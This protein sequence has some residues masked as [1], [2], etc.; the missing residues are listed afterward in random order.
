MQSQ[1]TPEANCGVKDR[2]KVT[3]EEIRRL[4]KTTNK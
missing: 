3:E 2:D 4:E 1:D